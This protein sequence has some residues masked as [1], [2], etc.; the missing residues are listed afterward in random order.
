MYNNIYV[1]VTQY[2]IYPSSDS[3]TS[4]IIMYV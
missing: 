1:Y 4:I 3:E 2:A